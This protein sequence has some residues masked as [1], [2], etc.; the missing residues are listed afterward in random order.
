MYVTTLAS[1]V[2]I[3]I[4]V[5]RSKVFILYCDLVRPHDKRVMCIHGS[6]PLMLSHH[7]VKFGSDRHCGSRDIMFL[8]LYLSMIRLDE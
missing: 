7:S 1:L 4:M 2:V 6:E 3:G 5:W 8:R